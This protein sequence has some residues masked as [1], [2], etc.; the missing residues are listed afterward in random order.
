MQ[1]IVNIENLIKRRKEL[2]ALDHLTLTNMINMIVNI[3]GLG[4]RLFAL[5]P[6]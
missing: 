2:L 3:L 1:T 6:Y 5:P 4:I